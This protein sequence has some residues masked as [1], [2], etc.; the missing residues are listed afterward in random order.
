MPAPLNLAPRGSWFVCQFL[1][2]YE[3]T[4]L[5]EPTDPNKLYDLKRVIED[6]RLLGR[7]EVDAFA[8]VYFSKTGK[9][10][11]LHAI[12]DPVVDRFCFATLTLAR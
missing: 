7:P 2:P 9:Q 3:C 10:E 6:Y 11:K 12:L 8:N 1:I 5:S 4:L